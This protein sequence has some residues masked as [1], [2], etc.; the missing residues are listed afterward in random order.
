MEQLLDASLPLLHKPIETFRKLRDKHELGI[1]ETAQ[2]CAKLYFQDKPPN[3][4]FHQIN[5]TYMTYSFT[6]K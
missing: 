4:I 3:S 6:A 2:N 1:N 5:I